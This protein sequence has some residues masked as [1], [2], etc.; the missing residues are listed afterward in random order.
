MK[1]FVILLVLSNIAY[2]GWNQGWLR[3]VP[4]QNSGSSAPTVKTAPQP[5]EQ[6]PA[7]LVL[8][9]DLPAGALQERE[10]QL[11]PATLI[12]ENQPV[13]VFP[14]PLFTEAPTNVV[15]ES[16]SELISQ[17]PVA[18][19][20]E[21]AEP[22]PWCAN[23][24]QFELESEARALLG[25]L[26]AMNVQATLKSN[27]VPVASTFWVYLPPFATEAAAFAKLEELQ[28]KSID[29]YYMRSGE[30]AGGISLGV[31]SRRESAEVAQT[32]L[33]RRGYQA[34]IGEVF[35]Q[36]VRWWLVLQARSADFLEG[37]DWQAF[38]ASHSALPMTENVCEVVASPNQFP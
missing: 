10:L 8:L 29:S 1:T 16:A 18:T 13:P 35:R 36:E 26:N 22:Q 14:E 12:E 5:Y 2:F 17:E 3:D 34:S 30:L 25:Q 23:L 28:D 32:T 21:A 7:K 20:T 31:F 37:P 11:P 9:S 6:A 19:A 27:R 24:G 4:M 38:R 15:Q 33:A